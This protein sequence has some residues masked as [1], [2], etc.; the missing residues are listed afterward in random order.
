MPCG[1]LTPC[2]TRERNPNASEPSIYGEPSTFVYAQGLSG[3]G[4]LRGLRRGNVYIERGCGLDFSINEGTALSGDDVG[5]GMVDYRLTV[6]D[7]ARRYIAE[8]IVDGECIASYPLGRQSVRFSVDLSRRAWARIDIRRVGD[9]AGR[10]HL[11]AEPGARDAG[12]YADESVS[13]SRQ[14]LCR[15]VYRLAGD[16]YE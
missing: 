5:G 3:N 8:C 9:D 6:A 7:T 14:P 4:I 11:R 13:V 16:E 2:G 1:C 10:S 12:G 15:R